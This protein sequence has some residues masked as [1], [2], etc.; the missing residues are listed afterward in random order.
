[1]I[2]RLSSLSL[3]ESRRHHYPLFLVVVVAASMVVQRHHHHTLY[4]C[5][6]VNTP[7]GCTPAEPPGKNKPSPILHPSQGPGSNA[8][9][10]QLQMHQGGAESIRELDM[11]ELMALM[12]RDPGG[13]EREELADPAGFVRSAVRYFRAFTTEWM[14]AKPSP[15]Q[16]GGEETREWIMGQPSPLIG[17]K[18]VLEGEEAERAL[19]EQQGQFESDGE[20]PPVAMEWAEHGEEQGGGRMPIVPLPFAPAPAPA[21][22][23]WAGSHGEGGFEGFAPPL[24]GSEA[25]MPGVGGRPPAPPAPVWWGGSDHGEGVFAGIP[26]PASVPGAT[27]LGVG[28]RPFAPVPEANRLGVGPRR[29]AA[30]EGR[31]RRKIANA[32]DT[33]TGEAFLHWMS[34]KTVRELARALDDPGDALIFCMRRCFACGTQSSLDGATFAVA[35]DICAFGSNRVRRRSHGRTSCGPSTSCWPRRCLST[36]PPSTTRSSGWP[37]PPSAPCWT[38]RSGLVTD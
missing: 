29:G 26:P 14:E 17:G 22:V 12:E 27:V 34:I 15:L 13:L 7:E 36:S 1:M 5:I 2:M 8:C 11:V 3:S 20:A 16:R 28:A 38:S 25:T 4:H 19:A 32:M 37:S 23:P 6:W 33:T 21:P 10:P 35:D 24:P 30:K 31:K 9:P 18:G